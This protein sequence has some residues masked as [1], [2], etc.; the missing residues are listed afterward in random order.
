MIPTIRAALPDGSGLTL[1]LM[2]DGKEVYS[3]ASKRHEDA[4]QAL[5]SWARAQYM[6]TM[7]QQMAARHEK[8][9]M[10]AAQPAG[11]AAMPV[12][13]LLERVIARSVAEES[14]I[15]EHAHYAETDRMKSELLT[16]LAAKDAEIGLTRFERDTE[17]SL[18]EQADA[19]IAGLE[20]DLVEERARIASMRTEWGAE[21][22]ALTAQVRQAP[23]AEALEDAIRAGLSGTYHCTRVWEAWNVGTMSEE[24]FA[25][26]DESDTPREIAAAVMALVAPSKTGEVAS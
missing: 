24:D 22:A 6:S 17:K 2:E 20:A 14:M 3:C 12:A 23:N 4:W 9:V 5:A 8:V 25:P 7:Q 1:V 11:D 16:A 13:D 18:R 10:G 21:V 26:V 19:R 15:G